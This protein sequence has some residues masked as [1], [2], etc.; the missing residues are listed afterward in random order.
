MVSFVQHLEVGIVSHILIL[1]SI[2]LFGHLWHS[3]RAFFKVWAGLLT[4]SATV[5][6]IGYGQNEKF[7]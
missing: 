1:V 2:F 3:G 4:S 6:S 5:E 7:G